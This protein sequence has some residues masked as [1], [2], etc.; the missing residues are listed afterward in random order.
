[1]N[2]ASLSEEAFD[3]YLETEKKKYEDMKEKA[4]KKAK[5]RYKTL[6]V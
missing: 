4:A 5:K 1:M 2:A 3:E 6:G